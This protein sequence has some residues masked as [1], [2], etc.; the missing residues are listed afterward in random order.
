MAE[1]AAGLNVSTWSTPILID[2]TPAVVDWISDL[3]VDM[4]NT[5]TLVSDSQ[6]QLSAAWSISEPET[7]MLWQEIMIGTSPGAGDLS[8][9]KKT[10]QRAHIQHCSDITHMISHR[11]VV[12]IFSFS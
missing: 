11:L 9:T 6:L 1:N 12:I 2:I 4:D 7:A 10:H 3:G 5:M 8:E